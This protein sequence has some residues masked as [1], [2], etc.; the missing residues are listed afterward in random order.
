MKITKLQHKFWAVFICLSVLGICNLSAQ[1]IITQADINAALAGTG[2]ITVDGNAEILAN[3]NAQNTGTAKTLTITA[4]GDI[5]IN[6]NLNFSGAGG[7]TSAANDITATQR[8]GANGHSLEITAGGSISITGSIN[9][10]GGNAAPVSTIGGYLIDRNGGTGGNSGNVKITSAGILHVNSI[11]ANGGN[12]GT[13]NMGDGAKPVGAGG[14]AGTITLEAEGNVSTTGAVTANAGNAGLNVTDPQGTANN[15]PTGKDGGSIHI[16]SK[17]ESVSIAGAISTTGG[18]GAGQSTNVMVGSTPDRNYAS[19]DGGNGGEVMISSCGNLDISATITANGGQPGIPVGFPN[20]GGT[21]YNQGGAGGAGGNVTLSSSNGNITTAIIRVNGMNGVDSGTGMNGDGTGGSL[22]ADY[23]GNGGQGGVINISAQK[24]DLLATDKIEANGGIGGNHINQGCGGSGGSGGQMDIKIAFGD[25]SLIMSLL[26]AIGGN[27]GT[28]TSSSTDCSVAQ[29]GGIGF[30]PPT[31]IVPYI[32]PTTKGQVTVECGA[33]GVVMDKTITE[34]MLEE[35][36]VDYVKNGTE[37]WQYNNGSGWKDFP[38]LPITITEENKAE[39]SAY[40]RLVYIECGEEKYIVG[41][42]PEE[43]GMIYIPCAPIPP[44][45]N[46]CPPIPSAIIWGGDGSL[47]SKFFEVTGG[48]E[49]KKLTLFNRSGVVV[50]D[51]AG[52]WDGTIK[53][54][55]ADPGNYYYVLDHSCFDEIQKGVIRVVK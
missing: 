19:T 8:S 24:G 31:L 7:N 47:N 25:E 29:S 23:G 9:T 45:P 43:D 37:R 55:P 22:Y 50:F 11:L 54:K 30:I 6:A 12:G 3:I 32:P 2:I 48:A 51:G 5:T 34:E 4:T 21:I 16:T 39:Y 38:Q 13:A 33:D 15:V 18:N 35:L 49:T 1:T 42:L 26:E 41:E 53:G 52:V 17:G 46:E 28:D 27:K 40:I 44:I 10:S 36:L 20:G 14:D